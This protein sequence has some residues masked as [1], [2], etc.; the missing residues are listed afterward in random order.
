MSNIVLTAN[1][2]TKLDISEKRVSFN[3]IDIE[4][5]I[6]SPKNYVDLVT[7]DFARTYLE[8]MKIFQNEMGYY[9][10]FLKI[11]KSKGDQRVHV[12]Y[13]KLNQDNS[14]VFFERKMQ[15]LP[16]K[17]STVG[18]ASIALQKTFNLLKH[19]S[20]LRIY[21]NNY[22]RHCVHKP[23]EEEGNTEKETFVDLC[24]IFIETNK[25]RVFYN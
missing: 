10:K 19:I 15:S 22:L 21:S 13:N 24:V 5:V 16:V 20:L 1:T 2:G 12:L 7:K 17:F 18:D 4:V 6:S 25:N 11:L 3:D 9:D 8:T 23:L 14:K